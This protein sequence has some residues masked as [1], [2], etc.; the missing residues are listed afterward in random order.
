MVNSAEI[1]LLSMFKNVFFCICRYIYFWI[2]YWRLRRSQNVCM[3]LRTIERGKISNS[4]HNSNQNL[5]FSR[6]SI[7]H[8]S[9][10]KTDDIELFNKSSSLSI[11]AHNQLLSE[12]FLIAWFD[13][14]IENKW[15]YIKLC[16]S[17]SPKIYDIW[18]SSFRIKI[19]K[20]EIET[21]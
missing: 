14:E 18:N 3:L 16:L 15:M 20:L 5:I 21:M 13:W 9:I 11:F 6:L 1:F 19:Q 2:K 8:S 10:P 12:N 17:S 7:K 4:E